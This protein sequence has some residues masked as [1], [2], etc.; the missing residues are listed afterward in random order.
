MQPNSWLEPFKQIYSVDRLFFIIYY[1]H[2]LQVYNWIVG[3]N[4]LNQ[5]HSADKLFLVTKP[6][7]VH[8]NSKYATK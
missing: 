4:Y 3:W 7:L 1:L 5:M 8:T 6:W 2:K